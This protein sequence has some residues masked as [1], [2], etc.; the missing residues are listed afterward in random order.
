MTNNSVNNDVLN[1][2]IEKTNSST[3]MYV[4]QVYRDTLKDLIAVFG[5]LYYID[6]DNNSIQVKCTH[7]NKERAI[8]KSFVGDNI[9]LPLITIEESETSNN[10]KRNKYKPLLVHDKYWDK[11]KNRAIRILSLAPKAV[12]I[13]YRINIW[14]KYKQDMDQLR[15]AIFVLFNPD[16]ELQTRHDCRTK[17]YFSGETDISTMQAED[18]E[19]RVLKKSISI[20]VETYIPNPK[21]LFTSTGKI[22]EFKLDVEIDES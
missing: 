8:A 4:Q 21:F 19:D 12:D 3:G 14:S 10:E 1:Q 22:E 9:T 17:A 15:E 16:I 13:D 11:N 6:K 2:I 7:A 18:T 5:N 20:T